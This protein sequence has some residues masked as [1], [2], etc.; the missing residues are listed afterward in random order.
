MDHKYY[1]ISVP[2]STD[3]ITWPGD[4]KVAVRQAASIANGDES[5]ISLIRMC[6]HTGTH[7][8]APRH[9]LN[10]GKT[11]DQIALAKL[12]GPAL[13]MQITEDI[14]VITGAVI[15]QHPLFETLEQT[16]KVL[17]KTRNSA[18]WHDSNNEFREDYI[19]LDQTA[20][21]LLA[22]LD[23]ELVGVDYLSIA[24]FKTTETPHKILLRK[25]VVLLEG[26]DLMAVPEGRYELDCLPL[27]IRGC[28]GSPARAILKQIPQ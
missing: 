14:D 26:I 7:I 17:F 12:V 16:K 2:I 15:K 27:L 24:T 9:F 6:V 21:Q 4:P 8:D 1:D 13:V 5:N 22:D 23:M 3:T 11:I 10:D 20:A 28:E 25:E 18:Y 19:G